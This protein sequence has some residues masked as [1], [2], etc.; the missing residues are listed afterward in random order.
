MQTAADQLKVPKERQKT[1]DVP[2]DDFQGLESFDPTS[3]AARHKHGAHKHVLQSM[4]K[5][6]VEV[7]T[8]KVSEYIQAP[9]VSGISLS[10]EQLINYHNGDFR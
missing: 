6:V 10:P 9:I 4:N 3:Q 2:G 7:R 5:P 1:T 8:A